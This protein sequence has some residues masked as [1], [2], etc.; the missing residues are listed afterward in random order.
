MNPSCCHAVFIVVMLVKM[1][2]QIYVQHVSIK[3]ENIQT[4]KEQKEGGV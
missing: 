3:K 4:E 2:I 1:D